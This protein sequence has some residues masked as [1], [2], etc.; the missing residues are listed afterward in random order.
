MNWFRLCV[1]VGSC[2]N[3]N[4]FSG[5]TK[6]GKFLRVSRIFTMELV[7]FFLILMLICFINRKHK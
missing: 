3:G 4:E 2:E 1:L 5:S 6:G 7:T